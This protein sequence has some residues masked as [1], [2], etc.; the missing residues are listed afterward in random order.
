[1]LRKSSAELLVE[2]L[3]DL[4]R[5]RVG[6]A[7]STTLRDVREQRELADDERLSAH[8][9]ERAIEPAA[10]VLEDAQ[11]GGLPREASRDVRRVADGHPEQDEEAGP[12][13][14]DPLSGD[15]D[16]GLA[17]TLE[18][19]SHATS[20]TR[21]KDGALST[22]TL[23]MEAAPHPWPAIGS[24]MLRDGYVTTEELEEILRAQ[25]DSPD[26]RL[27]GW[28]LGEILVERGIMTQG[29]V[30]QLVAEQYELPYLEL[31]ASAVDRAVVDLLP[32]ELAE[33]FSALPVEI[34]SDGS[35]VLAVA[36]PAS[37]LFSDELRRAV[38]RPL[39]FVVVAQDAMAET[40][41]VVRGEAEPEQPG[42]ALAWPS[43][44]PSFH[45]PED[46]AADTDA[47]S[48]EPTSG[49]ER[50]DERSYPLF[51]TLLMRDGLVS[52][53]EL[54]AALAEQR[55][56]PGK[57]L[58][59][60]LVERGALTRA[61]V[62]RVVAE[63]YELEFLDLAA[64][65]VD[66]RVAALL[67]SNVAARYGAL[68]LDFLP[69]GSLRVAVA[70]PTKVLAPEEIL[71][72]LGA[73][74]TFAVA[75]PEL[76]EATLERL[77]E[78][79][80]STRSWASL[81]T[82]DPPL[83]RPLERA[84]VDASDLIVVP[85]AEVAPVHEVVERRSTPSQAE[86][87]EESALPDGH[88]AAPPTE[89]EGRPERTRQSRRWFWRR[90]NRDGVADDQT[91]LEVAS[92]TDVA[93]TPADP[94]PPADPLADLLLAGEGEDDADDPLADDSPRAAEQAAVLRLWL[95]GDEGLA[96]PTEV[97]AEP[98]EV[99]AER[100]EAEHAAAAS[101][102]WA[103][104]RPEALGEDEV[105]DEQTVLSLTTELAEPAP[106]TVSDAGEALGVAPEWN[107]FAP[108]PAA[109]IAAPE[110]AVEAAPSLGRGSETSPDATEHES[111]TEVDGGRALAVQEPEQ[112]GEDELAAFEEPALSE[113]SPT[114]DEPATASYDSDVAV[115]RPRWSAWEPAAGAADP[116]RE[117]ALADLD[118]Q[119]LADH[120]LG[121]AAA[122]ELGARESD[123][124]WPA[125]LEPDSP[126]D[127]A[128]PWELEDAPPAEPGSLFPAA[129]SG[130][131]APESLDASP[132]APLVERALSLGAS[133]LHFSAQEHGIVVRARI[134]G[135]LR[136]LELVT[137]Q[138]RFELARELSLAAQEG[139][140]AGGHV[141]ALPTPHG[142]TVS[143]RFRTS[144]TPTTLES[145][146]LEP[147]DREALERALRQ[148]FG[149]VLVAGPSS[150]VRADTLSAA[151]YELASTEGAVMTIEDPILHVIP[152]ADQVAV[153]ESAGRGYADGLRALLSADPDAILV[154]ELADEET[155]RLA[156]D[157][158]TGH[159]VVTA[160]LAQSAVGAIDRLSLYR[161]DSDLLASTLSLVVAQR[162]VR[163]L[164]DHCREGYYATAVDAA[165]LRRPDEEIGRRLLARA[166]GCAECGHTGFAGTI[167]MYEVLTPNDEVRSLIA[168]NAPATEIERAARLAG[169]RTLADD[170]VRLVLEGLTT[171]AEIQRALG[172]AF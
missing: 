35:L 132:L 84:H 143:V 156:V 85:A 44:T 32:S 155:A 140:L 37:V 107:I 123:S 88:A 24:L 128:A 28:R 124:A 135:V 137:G 69:D 144:S 152:G 55:R 103:D 138:A 16:K 19:R 125:E 46:E 39:R 34:A 42:L 116:W 142:E 110:T 70:D 26:H 36:D 29:Q 3:R 78:Q 100:T 21:V 86:V 146:T 12:A 148:P 111:A 11:L 129:V 87:V 15:L 158:A 76:I 112:G 6:E 127:V 118:E 141:T 65:E 121:H 59:E 160:V 92:D 150:S 8:V 63:Q 82:V 52:E 43:G 80:D 167:G 4:R 77:R 119:E 51:G 61:D 71:A 133:T 113:A 99:E 40:L 104:D 126:A 18:H 136:K 14:G 2:R 72:V 13:P 66:P 38:G 120:P 115:E 147:T 33:R 9:A 64:L 57:R 151:L 102:S 153:D 159:L 108:A 109:A 60:I 154:G 68:P 62:A 31:E 131:A 97:E 10:L 122:S 139:R 105:G 89:T 50:A 81:A 91:E 101:E 165:A 73:R 95:A 164:C 74:L 130:R 25:H 134:D 117:D 170:A 22:D 94:A 67:P 79:S 166:A 163:R 168:A 169:K 45:F 27:S 41:A 157:A 106:D 53:D 96:A 20:V 54:E 75:D 17:H 145:L 90:R 149:L 5:R 23:L 56:S 7:R 171:V 114:A 48:E 47:R 58:G 172:R 98:P 1:M 162:L 93:E 49:A 83:T 161:V 30:A